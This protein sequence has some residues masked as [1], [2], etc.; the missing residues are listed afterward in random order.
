LEVRGFEGRITVSEYLQSTTESY[1]AAV[2]KDRQTL[3]DL[4]DR[5]RLGKFTITM[6]CGYEKE[7]AQHSDIPFEDLPCPCGKEHLF[8]YKGSLV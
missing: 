1:T 3:V 4:M 2:V 6:P 7:F 5:C 8:V